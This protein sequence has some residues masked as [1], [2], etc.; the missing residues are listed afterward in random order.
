MRGCLVRSGLIAGVQSGAF[1]TGLIV[2]QVPS[3]LPVFA[4]APE[5]NSEPD[6]RTELASNY[7]PEGRWCPRANVCVPLDASC[8]PQACA[9]GSMSAPRLPRATYA[10]W[11]EFLFSVPAGP[12]TQYSVCVSG[13]VPSTS[14]QL[15]RLPFLNCPN[16]WASTKHRQCRFLCTAQ[17]VPSAYPCPPIA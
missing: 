15:P 2:N 12:P 5:S 9:N 3:T 4:V 11:R 14:D 1:L 8:H 6:N 17:Q 13:L 16:S 7:M 10:L